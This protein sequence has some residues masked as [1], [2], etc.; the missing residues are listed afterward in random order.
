MTEDNPASILSMWLRDA[1]E[2]LGAAGRLA[3]MCWEGSPNEKGFSM[4]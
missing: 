1:R 2:T 3:G 4:S